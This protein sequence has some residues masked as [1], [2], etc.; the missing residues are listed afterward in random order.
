MGY[1]QKRYMQSKAM[2]K[3]YRDPVL[4][5][6]EECGLA[7]AS[8]ADQ[9]PSLM[10]LV[11]ARARGTDALVAQKSKNQRQR[12][13]QQPSR[14]STQPVTSRPIVPNS[15]TPHSQAEA[16]PPAAPPRR[17]MRLEVKDLDMSDAESVDI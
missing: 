1:K 15:P 2:H 16:P 6:A 3:L 5:P 10:D 7:N 4:S 11:A 9:L 14:R 8:F 17:K 12:K 13:Q